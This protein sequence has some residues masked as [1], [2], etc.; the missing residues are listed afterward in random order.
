MFFVPQVHA[1]EVTRVE[2]YYQGTA[3]YS[4]SITVTLGSAPTSGEV[5]IVDIG[6]YDYPA[7]Y[8][9]GVSETGVTWTHIV[10]DAS[11]NDYDAEIWAGVYTSAASATITISLNAEIIYDG[12]TADACVYSGLVIATSRGQTATSSSY[13]GTTTTP[14]TGA[15]ATT[16][17]PDELEIGNIVDQSAQSSPTNGF[18]M[19]DGAISGA[20]GNEGVAYLENIVSATGTASSGTTTTQ[21]PYDACIATFEASSQPPLYTIT[22]DSAAGNQGTFCANQHHWIIA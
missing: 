11:S 13:T 12:A 3:W 9:T 1:S 8:V 21:G 22:V 16:S 17:V 4:S 2:G 15:T 14:V 7:N 6:V 10:S 18:T 19:I 5:V 20:G